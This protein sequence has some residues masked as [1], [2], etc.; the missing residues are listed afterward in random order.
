MPIVF[1]L[2]RMKPRKVKEDDAPRTIACPH[3]VS[4]MVFVP[5]GAVSPLCSNK[6]KSLDSLAFCVIE[7]LFKGG[8][9]GKH[10]SELIFMY[11]NNQT[12]S[13]LDMFS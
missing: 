6:S 9:G 4:L 12:L 11:K 5:G 13:E 7:H 10:W 2:T 3:K 1:S 8:G